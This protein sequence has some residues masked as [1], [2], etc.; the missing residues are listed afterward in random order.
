MVEIS[1]IVSLAPTTIKTVGS[2][3]STRKLIASTVF[4]CISFAMSPK[5][6]VTGVAGAGKTFLFDFIF[7]EI[8]SKKMNRPGPSVKDENHILYLGSGAFPKKISI[9]PGQEMAISHELMSKNINNNTTLN[10]IIHLVDF[11]HSTPRDKYSESSFEAKGI[12]NFDE[13]R[14]YNLMQEV[15][16]LERLTE[17]LRTSQNKPKWFCLVL[18]KTDLYKASDA[19][20][21][22][23]N[24]SSFTAQLRKLEEMFPNGRLATFLPICSDISTISYRKQNIHPRYVKNH[25]ESVNMLVTLLTTI[26]M[27]DK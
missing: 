24:N 10:G 25:S 11:G 2:L 13:L 19:I 9:I 1:S 6:V 8:K 21:Y 4:N 18:S 7:Q 27:M 22:Y 17:R 3:Y 20:K 23:E 16:Y 15:E 5:I 26:E 12:F 14:S